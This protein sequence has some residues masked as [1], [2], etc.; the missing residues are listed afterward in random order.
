VRRGEFLDALH[1]A[2]V[3]S[4]PLGELLSAHIAALFRHAVI[5]RGQIGEV[6]PAP[7]ADGQFEPLVGI[8]PPFRDRARRQVMQAI[9]EW[10]AI[11]GG[12]GHDAISL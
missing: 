12:I 9:G 11:G 2:R 3:G 1:R 7:H 10:A 8:G 5:E 6:L 4:V